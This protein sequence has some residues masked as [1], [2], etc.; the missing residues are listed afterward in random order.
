[1]SEIASLARSGVSLGLSDLPDRGVPF[2]SQLIEE[3][4]N[5]KMLVIRI[6][7]AKGAKG[8]FEV[9]DKHRTAT[10][11]PPPPFAGSAHYDGCVASRFGWRGSL[12]VSLPGRERISLVAPRFGGELTP[13]GRCPKVP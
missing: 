3:R 7:V 5:F 6:A 13:H 10:V 4:R 1:L 2:K 12:S 9:D 8:S 11:T